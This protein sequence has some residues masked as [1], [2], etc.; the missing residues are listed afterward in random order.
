MSDLSPLLHKALQAARH[1]G[2]DHADV[3]VTSGRGHSAMIRQGQA[4]GIKQTE[5]I[6]LGL[7]VFRGKR[8]ATV[9]GNDTSPQ[10][11]DQLAE[12]A[13]AMAQ[14]VPESPFDGL[15]DHILTAPTTQSIQALDLVDSTSPLETTHLLEAAKQ[16][17]TAALSHPGIT[18]SSG[19]SASV[20]CTTIA[21]ATSSGFHG[22]YQHSHYGLGVSVL[23]GQGTSMER[24]YAMHSAL[25]HADLR[26]PEEIGHEAAKR[27]LAR[28]NPSRPKT[29]SYPV[30]FDHRISSSLLEHLAAAINGATIAQE[31][32]FLTQ[33]LNQKIFADHITIV[34]DPT[35]PRRPGSHPF[36]GEGCSSSRL[37]LV[38][39]GRLTQW[40]LDSRCARQLNLPPN[41]RAARSLNGSLYPKCSNLFLQPSHLSPTELYHDITEGIMITELMGNSINMLTGDYSRGASGF[42]IR[43]GNIAEPVSGLTIAGNLNDMFARLQPANDLHDDHSIN[44]P[45]L[46]INHM[47]IAGQ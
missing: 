16:M 23:A 22:A 29:G 6:H 9:S 5:N 27:T 46:R 14:A 38:D 44:A 42:M 2:A 19:S 18:N 11:L 41:G 34:D 33:K 43:H 3:V 20:S 21:L 4:E 17:E 45:S 15:A 32:S 13:C 30:I 24:D 35:L 40:L 25:H 10:T 36:D 8:V 39:N 31:A 12:C 47:S 26:N 1:Y 7:R 37:N 28:L